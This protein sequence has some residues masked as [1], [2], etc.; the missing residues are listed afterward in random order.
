M[1]RRP[2]TASLAD[3]QS[4]AGGVAAVDRAASLLAAFGD[5]TPVLTLA[6]L[7]ECTRLYKSTVLRLLASLQHA[8]LVQR[9]S[10]GRYALGP[11]IARLY[12]AYTDAFAL[13]PV[14]MPVLRELAATTRESAA[15]HVPQ[16]DQRLCLYR[17]NSPQPVRDHARE[18]DLLPLARGAG[19]RVLQAYRGAGDER[20]GQEIR[21][22]QVVVLAGD[23]DPELAGIAAPVFDARGALLGALTL[24]MPRTRLQPA[25][26]GTVLA[27]AR[28]LSRQLGGAFPEPGPAPAPAPA[29]DPARLAPSAEVAG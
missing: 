29:Q 13:E 18:G 25:W 12:A 11:S 3:E 27:A 20:L 10:D 24:T 8:R 26:A 17:V 4:A 19:G 22:R 21:H 16:A 15:L 6:S 23:R 1:P 2:A 7:A 9:Q 14:V 5:G 28:E